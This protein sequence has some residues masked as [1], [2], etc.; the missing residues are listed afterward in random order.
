M[1]T[2]AKSK[3]VLSIVVDYFTD[4]LSISKLACEK[5]KKNTT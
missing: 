5:K 2:D 3:R 1:L 4:K